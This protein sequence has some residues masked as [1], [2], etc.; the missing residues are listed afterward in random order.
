[1]STELCE[2]IKHYLASNAV[3]F[4]LLHH[5]PTHT[6]AESAQARG[7]DVSIGGKAIV[8]KVGERFR[9]FVLSAALKIDSAKIKAHFQEKRTRFATSEELM[10]LTGVV[11]GAVPP[12]GEPILPL[13]LFVDTSILANARIAFN[14]GSLTDSIIMDV[15][16]YLRLVNPTLLDFAVK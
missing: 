11:P 4:K 8:M 15:A 13:E 16:D 1:M 12:F 3:D 10:Q 2:S 14:A 6:S 5:Q 9:L 7:E